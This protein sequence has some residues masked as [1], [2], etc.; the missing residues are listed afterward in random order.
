[1]VLW[2]WLKWMSMRYILQILLYC[3]LLPK[4]HCSL[5]HFLLIYFLSVVRWKVRLHSHFI[6]VH[7][8][9]SLFS[10]AVFAY[11]I[12]TRNQLCPCAS[13]IEEYYPRKQTLGCKPLLWHYYR[14]FV[15]LWRWQFQP[16]WP[17]FIG[18]RENDTLLCSCHRGTGG[19]NY[20][21][22]WTH[23]K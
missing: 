1:M 18:V 15:R 2:P 21:V 17:Y 9:L 22:M 6:R 19:T 7:C 8:D 20:V 5:C 12:C 14:L 16:G 23:G 3:F 11:L 10:E 13:A 4:M